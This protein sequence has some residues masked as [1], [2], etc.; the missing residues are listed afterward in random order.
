MKHLT[1]QAS[2]FSILIFFLFISTFSCRK[3][4][5]YRV[6]KLSASK[7]QNWFYQMHGDDVKYFSSVKKRDEILTNFRNS[8]KL[9]ESKLPIWNSSYSYK[10]NS[11]SITEFD[12]IYS[13]RVLDLPK[14]LH[15][16]YQIERFK[17][18]IQTKVLF[19]ANNSGYDLR[20][21]TI[22]PDQDYAEK[23]K[24]EIEPIR[25]NNFPPAFRGFV[26][27][28]DWNGNFLNGYRI[29]E[30]KVY[31][32]MK[33]TDTNSKNTSKI[34]ES[35]TQSSYGN[36]CVLIQPVG[37]SAE[38]CTS[39]Y[40]GSDIFLAEY[41]TD[42][43]LGISMEFNYSDCIIDIGNIDYS[44]CDDPST[45]YN[46]CFV[47]GETFLSLIQTPRNYNLEINNNLS[48]PCFVNA[49]A[50]IQDIQL[51]VRSGDIYTNELARMIQEKFGF[52]GYMRLTVNEGPIAPGSDGVRIDA[53]TYPTGTRDAI[54]RINTDLLTTQASQEYVVATFLHEF[55]HAY[56]YLKNE[57]LEHN[58]TAEE[59]IDVIANALQLYFPN[60]T[61]EQA[62][63]LA[64]GGLA[65]TSAWS[66]KDQTSK[67]QIIAT[68]TMHRN[69]N[70]GTTCN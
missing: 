4:D 56:L 49:F 38:I 17:R 32:E 23:E 24:Y 7:E 2:Y 20:V 64:W 45:P 51:V 44:G 40:N 43:D 47:S 37:R 13:V 69:G 29:N 41:C 55:A 11:L 67:N 63:H 39:L 30:G 9:R 26:I 6:E 1:N 18:S 33:I 60:L 52:S 16:K 21:M 15:S 66:L 19:I 42:I 3:S 70:T 28:S 48:S 61:K 65:D 46:D 59:Y 54:I 10:L 25:L 14:S 22:I 62:E 53:K 34:K 5:S 57:T 12:L 8:G 31:G 50:K 58:I 27:V 35:N 68:N 36:P